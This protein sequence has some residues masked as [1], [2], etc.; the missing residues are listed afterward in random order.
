[1]KILFIPSWYPAKN[2]N[3]RVAGT[4]VKEHVLAASLYD[5]IAVLVFR[6]AGKGFPRMRITQYI[7][8]GVH[9]YEAWIT[10]SLIPKTNRPFLYLNRYIALRKV[11]HMWKSPDLLH[12]QDT[13]SIYV[14][15]L[16]K[17]SGIPY[18]VSQH[19]SGFSRRTLIK[20][21]ITSFKLSLSNAEFVLP[22]YYKA[23][24]DYKYY[25]IDA[26]V[27]W[28]P[29]T[30]DTNIFFPN[31]KQS[32]NRDLLHVS[33]F[34]D[35]KR[36]KDIIKAF[37]SSLRSHPETHF[38]FVGDG[39][40][41]DIMMDYA[42]TILPEHSYTF[43]GHLSKLSIANLMREC[44]GFVF[45]SEF[46]TFGCVLMEAM[47]CGC[48]VLTTKTGGIP[49]VVHENEGIFVDVGDVDAIASGINLMLDG[50]HNLALSEIAEHTKMRFSRKVVGKKLHNIYLKA[51]NNSQSG[52][53]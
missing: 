30:F 12:S 23:A 24:M 36:V 48:P 18:V 11:I 7:D 35:Q 53:M 29:N 2:L 1:M 39:Q 33:G 41:K 21:Q 38:H 14:H 5:D 44:C 27:E 19:W 31:K 20:D 26:T 51:N 32:S 4:F 46:E 42:K 25:N 40:N 45:P 34:T 3:D 47:A 6:Y 37:S 10:D 49:S 17:I 9:T 13:S 16:S 28:I 52:N 50:K 43:H 15:W 8:S 22:A